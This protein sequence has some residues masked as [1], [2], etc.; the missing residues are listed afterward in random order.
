[1]DE[2]L[3]YSLSKFILSGPEEELKLTQNTQPAIMTIGV[4][5]FSVLNE[6][7]VLD[8]IKRISF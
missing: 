7:F 2:T 8:K 5:I 4:C 3:G 1:M 6:E